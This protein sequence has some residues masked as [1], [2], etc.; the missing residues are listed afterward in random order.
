MNS[1]LERSIATPIA[2]DGGR[3]SPESDA[4]EPMQRLDELMMVVEALCPVWPP[5]PPHQEGGRLLL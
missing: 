2:A 4:R 1:W 3:S 5:R